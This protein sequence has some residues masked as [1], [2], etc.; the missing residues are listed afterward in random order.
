M[1]NTPEE[2]VEYFALVAEPIDGLSGIISVVYLTLQTGDGNKELRPKNHHDS[3]TPARHP[4]EVLIEDE[5]IAA[6]DSAAKKGK[7]EF[8]DVKAA[9]LRFFYFLQLN[10]WVFSYYQNR[11]DSIPHKLW[12]GEIA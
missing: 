11:D 3:L 10:A 7:T 4:M 1:L 5:Q 6:H 9:R 2:R 8:A 12:F